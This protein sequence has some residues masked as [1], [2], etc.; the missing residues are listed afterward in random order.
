[1]SVAAGLTHAAGKCQLRGKKRTRLSELAKKKKKSFQ[2]DPGS[3]VALPAWRTPEREETVKW[4]MTCCV[5][6]LPAACL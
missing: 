1:M 6:R 2:V 5:W 3:Q 4:S